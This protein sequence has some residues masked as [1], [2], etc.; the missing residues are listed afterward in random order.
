MSRTDRS[1]PWSRA[2]RTACRSCECHG[3]C[4]YCYSNRMYQKH[5]HD[6]STK[7][8]MKE[9]SLSKFAF[10]PFTITVEEAEEAA[11]RG[12]KFSLSGTSP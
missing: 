8:Q 3:G 2:S 6:E 5:R 10:Q 9:V 11:M 7:Q 1:N 4:N 12:R